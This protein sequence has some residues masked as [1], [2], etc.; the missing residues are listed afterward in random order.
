M[1]FEKSI[2]LSEKKTAY[3]RD[4]IMDIRVDYDI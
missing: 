2:P 3:E 1:G 4:I